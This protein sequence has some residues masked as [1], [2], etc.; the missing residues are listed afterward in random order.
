M[1]IYMEEIFFLP[2][3]V[4]I[5]NMTTKQTIFFYYIPLD[6]EKLMQQ[7]RRRWCPIVNPR[8][9]NKIWDPFI[10]L[11]SLTHVMVSAANH[12]IKLRHP[13]QK[14]AAPSTSYILIFIRQC[15]LSSISAATVCHAHY[16][17]PQYSGDVQPQPSGL[18][19]IN[20]KVGGKK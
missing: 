1:L 12:K 16:M 18:V 11:R 6:Q 17:L 2:F 8:D 4:T 13:R 5:Q 3:I 20:I 7:H 15:H 14:E 9:Q 10:I 19:K